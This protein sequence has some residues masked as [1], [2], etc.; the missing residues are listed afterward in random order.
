MTLRG[1]YE[2]MTLPNAEKFEIKEYECDESYCNG[3]NDGLGT[4]GLLFLLPLTVA[5]IL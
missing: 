5:Y 3:S 4:V 1:C 2:N